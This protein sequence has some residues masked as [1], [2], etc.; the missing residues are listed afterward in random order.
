MRIFDFLKLNNKPKNYITLPAPTGSIEFFEEIKAISNIYWSE[1]DINKRIFGYQIQK[2]TKWRDGLS[3]NE[4]SDFESAIGFNFP[5]PLRNF[6]KTMNGLDKKGINAFGNSKHK[7]T[8]K[9]IYYSFPDDLEIIK[10]NIEQVFKATKIDKEELFKNGVSRIF[11]VCGHR[12]ILIDEPTNPILSMYYNDI[13]PW[14]DN[15]SKLI[16]TDIFTYINN[17]SDFESDPHN[18]K[19]KFWLEK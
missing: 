16:A 18:F 19:V 10:E 7:F 3:D 12:Y 15:L 8:F 13:V 9:P 1:T 4:I 17:V 5:A 2:D 6:Y 14:S 11:P